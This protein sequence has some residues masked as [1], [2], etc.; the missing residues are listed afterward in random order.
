VLIGI[1]NKQEA[2]N[3]MAPRALEARLSRGGR[4]LGAPM[5]ARL[6]AAPGKTGAFLDHILSE[7]GIA[8]DWELN[9]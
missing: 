1:S 9:E 5:L 6:L 4:V 8:V 7:T 3:A 2:L